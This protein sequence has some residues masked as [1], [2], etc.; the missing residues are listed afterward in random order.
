VGDRPGCHHP[1]GD[2]L[3]KVYIFAVECLQGSI[4]RRTFLL[5]CLFFLHMFSVFS[6]YKNVDKNVEKNEH[7]RDS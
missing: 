5:K 6:L 3:M 2:T 7:E 4:S 1:G